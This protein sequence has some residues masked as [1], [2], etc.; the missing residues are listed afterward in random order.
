MR[1]FIAIDLPSSLKEKIKKVLEKFKKCNLNA[2]WVESNN[3]HLTLKFLGEIKEDNLERIK[4]II[5]TVAKKISS[6]E[7][8]LKEFSFFP[9]P[10]NPRVF[11]ISTDKEEKLREIAQD[12]E[13]QLLPLGFKKE[14][15]FK[16]HITL[17]RFKSKKNIDCLKKELKN[18]SLKE[19]FLIKEIVLFKSILTSFGPI[20]EEIFKSN[21]TI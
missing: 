3:L 9:H 11:F 12:L 13:E 6:F 17:A 14:N 2:K 16:A 18:V 1:T 8:S 15:R 20:Y 5:D 21:L 19:D 4:K 7:V 10:N